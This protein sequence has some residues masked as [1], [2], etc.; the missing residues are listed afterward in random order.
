MIKLFDATLVADDNIAVDFVVL[1]TPPVPIEFD[2]PPTE[3]P[4]FTF[5]CDYSKRPQ[6]LRYE[7]SAD[8][9]PATRKNLRR[10]L[11]KYDIAM[12][13]AMSITMEQGEVFDSEFFEKKFAPLLMKRNAT[14]VVSNN[15]IYANLEKEEYIWS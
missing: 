13:A 5:Y 2:P 12:H 8:I 9:R 15:T 10:L 6:V 11:K 14:I 4:L 7:E 1:Q 3:T